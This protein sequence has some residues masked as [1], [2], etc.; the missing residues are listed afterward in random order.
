MA[1]A[2]GLGA[3]VLA[4][5]T[6]TA[7]LSKSAATLV[8]LLK[9]APGDVKRL[10]TRLRDLEVVLT[11]VDRA[12]SMNQGSA[13]DPGAERYWNDKREKLKS[14]F[15]EFED[16]ATRLGTNVVGTVGRTKWFLTGR[17]RTRKILGLLTE[18][19]DV[20]KTLNRL[21]MEP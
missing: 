1:E 18:D 2:V 6:I 17:D 5:F 19:I 11:Q 12:H 16:Y 10:G 8:D 15:A 13:M 9:D 3:G 4:F 14:D 7:K 20:L 21:M